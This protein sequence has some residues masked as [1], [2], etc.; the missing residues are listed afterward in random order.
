MLLPLLQTGGLLSVPGGGGVTSAEGD[1]AG[2]V[3]TPTT[4][5]WRQLGEELVDLQEKRE[6]KRTSGIGAAALAGGEKK[7]LEEGEGEAKVAQK[8]QDVV[9]VKPRWKRWPSLQDS[10]G[11]GEEEEEGSGSG[12]GSDADDNFA[13]SLSLSRFNKFKTNRQLPHTPPPVS[14]ASPAP[15]AS[16]STSTSTSKTSSSTSS[17]S[18]RPGSPERPL[19]SSVPKPKSAYKSSFSFTTSSFGGYGG[20]GFT[21]H[22]NTNSISSL[23]APLSSSLEGF[24]AEDVA[25]PYG[26]QPPSPRRGSAPEPGWGS[27]GDAS[28]GAPGSDPLPSVE[29]FEQ[30]KTHRGGEGGGRNKSES[31]IDLPPNLAIPP[32]LQ[33]HSSSSS[34]LSALGRPA[35]S[36][37]SLSATTGGLSSPSPP[38]SVGMSPSNSL[39]RASSGEDGS[40]PREGT[41]S[42]RGVSTTPRRG[43]TPPRIPLPPNVFKSLEEGGSGSAPSSFVTSSEDG[44]DTEEGRGRESAAYLPTPFS[45]AATPYDGDPFSSNAPPSGAAL[46]P[47]TPN[48]SFPFHA[49]PSHSTSS[50][51]TPPLSSALHSSPTSR[52]S[53]DWSKPMGPVDPRTYSA[54]TGLRDVRSFVVEDGEGEEQGRGAYGSV[55]RAR[56]R[57]RDGKAVGVRSLSFAFPLPFHPTRRPRLI[58]GSCACSRSSFSST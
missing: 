25:L 48:G 32:Y 23:H 51:F 33:H 12:S 5:E 21:S 28:G 22:S 41:S 1:D 29:A 36:R 40:N 20:G 53:L 3:V 10:D 57:G 52:V 45:G 46:V 15:V 43:P 26:A 11:E 8:R 6:R 4:E 14:T 54:V 30:K 27:A 56:E 38:G 42:E 16:T 50:S 2:L 18:S 17:S 7:P 31:G 35:L 49:A 44:T 55:R 19:L 37:G 58:G 9:G 24:S 34:S 13:L 47:P 39:D